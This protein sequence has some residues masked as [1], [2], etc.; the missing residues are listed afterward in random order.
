MSAVPR[1]RTT[2]GGSLEAIDV[3]G[4]WVRVPKDAADEIERLQNL[5][6]APDGKEHRTMV[7]EEAARRGAAEADV[8]RLRDALQRSHKELRQ[9]AWYD[10]GLTGLRVRNEAAL[11][12]QPQTGGEK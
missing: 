5:A 3:D 11:A 6:Y 4:I 7:F 8:A 9:Y 10:Q 2:P 12:N 1:I